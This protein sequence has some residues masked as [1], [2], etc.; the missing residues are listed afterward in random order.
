M[1]SPPMPRQHKGEY[2][3]VQTAEI[4]CQIAA[5]LP[6]SYRGVYA[7]HPRVREL[8]HQQNYQFPPQPPTDTLQTAS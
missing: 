3:E 7:D 5:L 6:P 2:L 1:P 8:L 4:M